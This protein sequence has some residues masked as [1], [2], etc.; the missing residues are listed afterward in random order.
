MTRE[1][2]S[3]LH[4]GERSK[5]KDTFIVVIVVQQHFL[6]TS[7]RKRTQISVARNAK[8]LLKLCSSALLFFLDPMKDFATLKNSPNFECVPLAFLIFSPQHKMFACP[9]CVDPQ[10]IIQKA[11]EIS[12]FGFKWTH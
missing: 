3:Q 6:I 5:K 10:K 11:E 8:A 2:G 9:S 1:A 12:D 7:L 4:S